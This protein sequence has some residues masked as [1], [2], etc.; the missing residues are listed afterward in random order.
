MDT[1][2]TKN[3]ALIL[4][5]L[6]IKVSQGSEAALASHPHSTD[7]SQ[8]D[9]LALITLAL[10]Q[11]R[12]LC[13]GTGLFL[14]SAIRGNT[15]SY[16]F[17]LVRFHLGSIWTTRRVGAS[18]ERCEIFYLM[19]YFHGFHV[20]CLNSLAPL[21][22]AAATVILSRATWDN[23][24]VQ[25]NRSWQFIL[26]VAV[27]CLRGPNVW[28][29]WEGLFWVCLS[30]TAARVSVQSGQRAVRSQWLW[31]SPA[32]VLCNGD[33]LYSDL[34]KHNPH[35]SQS[36]YTT[37]EVAEAVGRSD[38]CEIKR[39]QQTEG[40]WAAFWKLIKTW[41]LITSKSQSFLWIH[42]HER[43]KESYFFFSAQNNPDITH[44]Q[45][46]SAISLCLPA[47]D[48]P[49]VRCQN[50]C[51]DCPTAP[52]PATLLQCSPCSQLTHWK[53]G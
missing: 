37:Y 4:R 9:L 3:L 15:H 27:V 18:R 11:T 31:S 40:M 36:I 52:P 42:A 21:D 44:A 51:Q 33:I 34:V 29:G 32:H 17:G 14:E 12:L 30:L 38:A 45:L 25:T 26:V 1:W 35:E 53:C 47:F 6:F 41:I 2:K 7:S 50:E 22:A 10:V 48:Q 23:W 20:E 13:K 8:D 5:V 46:S 16:K 49:P 43:D 24:G 39:H 19:L 28:E